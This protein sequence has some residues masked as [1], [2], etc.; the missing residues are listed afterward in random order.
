MSFFSNSLLKE[1]Q[2]IETKKSFE[3]AHTIYKQSSNITT[4]ANAVF[5]PALNQ[6]ANNNNNNNQNNANANI[7]TPKAD[8]TNLIGVGLIGALNNNGFSNTSVLASNLFATHASVEESGANKR[9]LS[10]FGCYLI[11]S[12]V[13]PSEFGEIVRKLFIFYYLSEIQ[14]ELTLSNKIRKYSEK[15]S[16]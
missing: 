4:N 10:R 11:L 3:Q 2:V 1:A 14:Q 9:L 15:Y 5:T 8:F 7:P 13:N 12:L 6:L 16:V